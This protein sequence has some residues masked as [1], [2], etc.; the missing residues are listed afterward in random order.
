M[1]KFARNVITQVSGFDNPVISGEL[2][3][4]QQTYWNL[5]LTS[6]GSVVNLTGATIDASIVRRTVTNLVDTR[7]GLSFDVGNYTPAPTPIALSTTN[8]VPANGSFTLLIDSNA[9]GLMSSDAELNISVEDCVAFTG[10]IKINY[11]VQ[12]VNPAQDFVIFL[13]FLVRSDGVVKV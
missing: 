5:Q 4:D 9:W 11:P 3:W 6:N 10:R 2:V 12:G 1:A 7:N 8:F 13:F